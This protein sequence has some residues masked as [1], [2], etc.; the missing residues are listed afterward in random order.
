[1]SK[2]DK[3]KPAICKIT[4]ELLYTRKLL[5]EWPKLEIGSNG[6]LCRKSG[7]NLQLVLPKKFHRLV[8]ME[9]HQEM[10]HLEI[11]R[12]LQLTR[13]RFYSSHMQ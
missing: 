6:L 5:P 11:D 10:G 9:L 1:V 2:L 3:R 8:C 12:V 4:R 13:E 7:Q